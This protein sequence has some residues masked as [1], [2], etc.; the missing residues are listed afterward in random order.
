MLFANSI[1]VKAVVCLTVLPEDAVEATLT[2]RIRH[3]QGANRFVSGY[4]TGLCNPQFR[5]FLSC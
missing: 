5:T 2:T 1:Y 4:Y 3:N